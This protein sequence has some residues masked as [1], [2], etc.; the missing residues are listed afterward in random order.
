MIY[1]RLLLY[2]LEED[3]GQF[4]DLN[5]CQSQKEHDKMIYTLLRLLERRKIPATD[6]ELLLDLLS[7]DP[8][9]RTSSDKLAGKLLNSIS[10]SNSVNAT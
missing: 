9:D 8:V 2:S 5:R 6:I 1:L 3:F 10:Q 7:R 4:K